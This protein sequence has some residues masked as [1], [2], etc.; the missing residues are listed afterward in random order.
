MLDRARQANLKEWNCLGDNVNVELFMNTGE[1]M[2]PEDKDFCEVIVYFGGDK[3]FNG[4]VTDDLDDCLHLVELSVVENC[5]SK[6]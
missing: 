1:I 2:V 6:A 3:D 4:A 5:H